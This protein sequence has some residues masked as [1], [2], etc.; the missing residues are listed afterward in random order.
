MT[1]KELEV[2]EPKEE[3]PGIKSEQNINDFFWE[4][5][6]SGVDKD[7]IEKLPELNVKF[8]KKTNILEDKMEKIN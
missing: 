5:Y 3:T 4:K 8:H 2:E 7:Y 6:L 1:E